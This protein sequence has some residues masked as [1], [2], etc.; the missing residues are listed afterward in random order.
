MREEI[1]RVFLWLGGICLSCRHNTVKQAQSMTI[2]IRT[3]YK[4]NEFD[5]NS[6]KKASSIIMHKRRQ[7]IARSEVDNRLDYYQKQIYLT[8]SL[9][10]THIR[11]YYTVELHPWPLAINTG[12]TK[13]SFNSIG[14]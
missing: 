2:Y 13:A 11:R 9:V 8:Y 1:Q 3:F 7:A 6:E 10:L 12:S 5:A 14:Y 4:D